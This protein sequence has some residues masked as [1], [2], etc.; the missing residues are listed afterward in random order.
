MK[1]F[2]IQM[3]A[4]LLTVVSLLGTA[5]SADNNNDFN[6]HATRL[7]A[8]LAEALFDAISSCNSQS[9]TSPVIAEDGSFIWSALDVS[10]AGRPDISLVRHFNSFDAREGLFGK[11]WSTRCEKSLIKVLDFQPVEEGSLTTEPVVQYIYRTSIGRRYEFSEVTPGNFKS[12]DGL[13]DVTLSLNVD[14]LPQLQDQNMSRELYNAQGRLISEIDRNGNA[15]NYSY[16]DG[17]LTRIADV[18]GRF[19]NL[20]YNSTGHVNRLVDHTDR[21]WLYA[22][23]NNG[24]LTSVTD[25]SGAATSYEYELIKRPADSHDYYGISRITDGSGVVITSVAY[26]DN[27]RVLS[28]TEGEN[29]YTYELKNDGYLYKTDSM[30]L[31]RSFLIDDMGNKSEM[32]PTVS[33]RVPYK[34][35]YN[36]NAQLVLYTNPEGTEFSFDYDDLGRLVSATTPD[37]TTSLDYVEG[38]SWPSAVKTASGRTANAQYDAKGNLISVTDPLG[39][40]SVMA[41]SEGGD[42]G[43]V[44]DALGN[45]VQQTVN[46]IGQVTQITDELNRTTRF[47]YNERGNVVSI[48]N[49]VDDGTTFTYD[50]LDRLLSSTDAL[51]QVTQYEYDLSGR[52]LSVTDAAGGVTQ[53]AYDAYGRLAREIRANKSE[54]AY[55]Y[56]L[57]NLPD[58]T[59]DPLGVSTQYTY[60]AGKRLTRVNAGQDTVGYQYDV[61]GRLTRAS[62]GA[63][64]TTYTYDSM[65]RPIS[66]TQGRRTI[67]YRYNNEGELSGM[68]AA[69]ETLQYTYDER[70]AL[71]SLTTPNGVHSYTHNALGSLIT[72]TYP[73]GAAAHKRYDNAGQL[74]EQD[75]SELGGSLLTYSYDLLGRVDNLSGKSNFPWSYQYDAISQ[76]TGATT[77]KDH[78][79]QYDSTGNRLDD[80]GSYD[81]FNQLAAT[82]QN[83]Y[84]YNAAGG[85]TSRIHR[86]TGEQ[87]RLSYNGFQRLVSVEIAPAADAVASTVAHYAYD[88]FG[89]RVSKSV[90]R[91]ATGFQWNGTDLIAEYS[92]SVAAKIYRY[93]GAYAPIEYVSEGST[94]SVLDDY[95]G[96]VT[97]LVDDARALVWQEG[98]DPYG[99]AGAQGGSIAGFNMGFPGQYHDAES[100]LEYNLYRYYDASTGR[101][102]S[103]DPIGLAGGVNRYAYAFGSP[104]HFYDPNGLVGI[105]QCIH[106]GLEF[107][108]LIPGFGILPDALNAFFYLAEGDRFNAGYSGLAAIPILGQAAVVGRYGARGVR[109]GLETRGYRPAPG[110][111]TIQG[112]VD[113]ATVAG[114]P[115]IQRGGQDLV[116][117][118][119]D[120]HGQVV[121]TAT[122][123]NIRR[124]APDG[125]VFRGKGPDREVTPRDIRELYNAQTRQGTSDLRTRSGR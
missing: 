48:N 25:P 59:V 84:T 30:G 33:S 51:G 31:R 27:A 78:D 119:S 35:E 38:T 50:V 57:D 83:T 114:N 97:A 44:T 36:Q 14:G 86:E 103:D 123:Q 81:A 24:T 104:A 53:F 68:D 4:V 96:S 94:Y 61:L 37:G 111:R 20:F 98:S 110:E 8:E 92:A 45:V 52:L 46:E 39:H 12:P 28:Y 80:G 18:H 64:V 15:V 117:L 1:V 55:T 74:V 71:A 3:M 112:Q 56:R 32:W 122:S 11:G 49:A 21:A 22:Y 23:A 109:G 99:D 58:T 91:V 120:G 7:G 41:W 29:T 70:G 73:N 16:R 95:L 42:L 101:Y 116:R 93:D 87:M 125:R 43:S 105:N 19:L 107:A 34:Y 54:Y 106:Y 66:E 47:V 40:V 90:N 85:L 89:R 115:T 65:H 82:N 102:T 2:L 113:A 62:A 69:G 63:T 108:G 75:Y 118:R 67:S 88:A 60:D 77:D 100:G 121:A 6:S 26:A 10:L 17:A 79:Y 124:V 13:T 72:H 76:L 5:N 9:S